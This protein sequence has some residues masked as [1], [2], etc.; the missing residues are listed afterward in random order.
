MRIPTKRIAEIGR[1]A[2]RNT[3][4]FILPQ[5]PLV[6]FLEQTDVS[7][8]SARARR[9][10]ENLPGIISVFDY[11]DPLI[12]ALVW[13]IK[14]KNNKRLATLAAEALYEHLLAEISDHKLFEGGLMLLI[15]PVPLAKKRL[16]ERGFNQT[17]RMAEEMLR[18]DGKQSFSISN[19][20][21]RTRETKSQTQ[22]KSRTERL[23]NLRG[24]F[25]VTNEQGMKGKHIIVLDDVTTTGAT[26]GE[27]RKVLLE[28]GAVSVTGLTLA[29]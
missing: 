20:V 28:T 13:E 6:R 15:I 25:K 27:I 29:H 26:I 2:L 4:D 22:T 12:K 5:P 11:K 16:R 1:I 23:E 10:G 18:L 3:L 21:S 8:L 19:G 9:A 24:A 7:A 14:F 17:E